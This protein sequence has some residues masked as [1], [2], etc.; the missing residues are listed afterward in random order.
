MH[1]SSQNT[2]LLMHSDTRARQK[3]AGIGPAPPTA[4]LV[5]PNPQ[6]TK[7]HA[8]HWIVHVEYEAGRQNQS[9]TTHVVRGKLSTTLIV[10]TAT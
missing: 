9:A 6:L 8:V 10:G 2:L 7:L 5:E 1:I 3:S 4:W